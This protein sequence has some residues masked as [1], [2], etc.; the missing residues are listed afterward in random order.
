MDNISV[1]L[2]TN[3]KEKPAGPDIPFGVFTTDHMFL[4]NYDREQGWHDPRI[5][6]YAPFQ[7]DPAC[8]V[9][10]Y[11]QEI[12][13]GMKAY[14][15]EEGRI[16]LF[17]PEENF[18]RM[19]DSCERMSIPK[20]DVDFCVEAVKQLVTLEKDWVPTA[21][22]TSLYIR[23]FIFATDIHVGVHASHTYQFAVILSPVGP[24]YATGLAPRRHR[25][26]QVR[27]QLRGLPAGRR[28]GRGEGLLPGP[29]ARRR[30]AQ[31]H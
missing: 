12:F 25:L 6:P 31:V 27:R 3:Y 8:M 23:P 29:L 4:M 22:N 17:R 14:R 13:E 5:V 18:K 24:Y 28:K 11:A 15:D 30:G 20:I 16:R 1:T 2:T 19:N 7:M 26:Y 10:H 21:P 9:L